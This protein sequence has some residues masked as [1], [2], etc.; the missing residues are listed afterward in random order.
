MPPEA[1]GRNLRRLAGDALLG[2]RARQCNGDH[3]GDDAADSGPLD[4]RFAAELAAALALLRRRPAGRPAAADRGVGRIL[5]RN[6]WR[7][8]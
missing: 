7:A 5:P 3:R 6:S 1:L 2:R 8:P 4:A